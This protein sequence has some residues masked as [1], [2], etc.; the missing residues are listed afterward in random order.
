MT[1]VINAIANSFATL[2]I[3]YYNWLL[4]AAYCCQPVTEEAL[5]SYIRIESEVRPNREL[6]YRIR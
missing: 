3:D 2:R 6:L 5:I 1:N 4:T